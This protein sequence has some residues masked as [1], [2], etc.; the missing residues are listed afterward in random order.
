MAD[1]QDISIEPRR[2]KDLR[3]YVVGGG[4]DYHAQEEDHW[5]LGYIATPM[6]IYPEYRSSRASWGLNVLGSLVVEVEDSTGEVG[7]GISTG[8]YP[9]AWIVKNHLS[10]FVIGKY[11]GEIEKTWD[12]MFRATAFYGRKGLAMYAISA[13]DLALWDLAGRARGLPVYDLLGGPVRDEIVFYATGPRPD[14]AKKKGFIGGKIPLKYGPAEGLEGLKRNVEVIRAWREEL[15]NDFMLMYDCWMSLD[16]PYAVKLASELKQY[17][18]YWIEEPFMP[19]DYWSHEALSAVLP[20]ILLASGEHEYTVHGFRALLEIGKVNVVQ[21][22]VTWVG[23]LTP[24][25]RIASLAEAYGAYVIPHGSSVYGYHFV[26]TRINSPFAEYIVVSK[27]AT[28]IIP[29]F[30]PLLIGEPTPENGRIRLD[31]K[32]G[33]GVKLNEKMLVKY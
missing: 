10:R 9:A 18:L 13:V 12:Q 6:S 2:I 3:V 24:M 20:P 30:H 14:I 8:G 23:G 21:P 5:I 32:P 29:Q 15:G 26:I 16:L 11:V 7:F 17:K 1:R 25:I 28:E 33:F 22:D 31:R 27:D 19:E 4:A